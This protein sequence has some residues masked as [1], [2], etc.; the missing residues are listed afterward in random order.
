MHFVHFGYSSSTADRRFDLRCS[1]WCE[2]GLTRDRSFHAHLPKCRQFF[3]C[4]TYI[5]VTFLVTYIL[6][7]WNDFSTYNC[8]QKKYAIPW[9][10]RGRIQKHGTPKK[11]V[12]SLVQK[13]FWSLQLISQHITAVQWLSLYITHLFK[14]YWGLKLP[15]FQGVAALSDS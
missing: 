13:W 9:T 12:H 10:T 4:S 2:Q 3:L 6:N 14:L 11:H 1:E 8:M 7:T 5:W 15:K